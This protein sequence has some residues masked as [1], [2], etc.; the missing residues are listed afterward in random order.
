MKKETVNR[1]SF[2]DNFR[3]ISEQWK[4][5]GYR[6]IRFVSGGGVIISKVV[7]NKIETFITKTHSFPKL[8][9][10]LNKD[11]PDFQILITPELN[12]QN[13]LV[14]TECNDYY[15]LLLFLLKDKSKKTVTVVLTKRQSS[16]IVSSLELD[17]LNSVRWSKCDQM[18]SIFYRR[19]EHTSIETNKFYLRQ[20]TFKKEAFTSDDY[21]KHLY[22]NEYNFDQSSHRCTI[23]CVSD[24]SHE[25]FITIILIQYTNQQPFFIFYRL[26]DKKTGAD[27][28]NNFRKTLPNITYEELR[29]FKK[30][31]TLK[32]KNP[33]SHNFKIVPIIQKSS[34]RLILATIHYDNAEKPNKKNTKLI[35][36][37]VNLDTRKSNE[38]SSDDWNLGY[39]SSY[40]MM[41][42]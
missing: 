32:T 7:D 16:E 36:Y 13:N 23:A 30:T 42:I 12:N 2:N 29:D 33:S 25:L 38:L 6:G 21:K 15:C 34:N 41:H 14:E 10:K 40:V 24:P 3:K 19:E 27:D 31:I 5:D 9:K 1:K 28:L 22:D 18:I 35:M 20:L 26:N 11:S 37:S 17:Q 8:S 39:L 4:S